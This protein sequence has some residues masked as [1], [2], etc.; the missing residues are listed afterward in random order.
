[1][2]TGEAG[3]AE[4]CYTNIDNINPPPIALGPAWCRK[5]AQKVAKRGKKFGR[6]PGGFEPVPGL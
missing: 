6:A 2:C 4:A 5:R 1:V 3:S